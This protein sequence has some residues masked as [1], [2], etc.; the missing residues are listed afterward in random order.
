MP[1]ILRQYVFSI[2]KKN[3][4]IVRLGHDLSKKYIDHHLQ[5]VYDYLDAAF[6]LLD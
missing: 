4:V 2:P 5:D 1:G 6:L 3:A